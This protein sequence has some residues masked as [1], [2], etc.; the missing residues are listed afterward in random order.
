MVVKSRTPA[1]DVELSAASEDAPPAK[2]QAIQSV[3]SGVEILKAL[4]SSESNIALREVSALSGMS[5]SQAHRYLLAYVNAGLVQQDA[6]TGRYGLGPLALKLGLAALMRTDAV[7]TA[8]AHM[9]DLVDRTGCTGLITV[10]S[11]R[12]P[13]VIRWYDGLVP[14]VASIRVG[15]AV[16]V[17]T[18]A[19]GQCFLAFLPPQLTQACVDSELRQT[20]KPGK[21]ELQAVET[22]RTE[23]RSKGHSVISN[24][25]MPG[26]CAVAAPVFNCQ[27]S[28]AVVLGLA[29]KEG[30][31][32]S[33]DPSLRHALFETATAASEAL[34]HT[35][36]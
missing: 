14:V 33:Q 27:G 16:P 18:S 26:L 25:M 23:V 17:L 21:T 11:D 3:E 35:P 2:R 13:V 22:L 20:G 28:V 10:W 7:A 34:G 24:T 15:S 9:T 1:S 36:D 31:R 8:S 4:M 32:L 19:A 6:A 29:G 30:D 5:R 12:G